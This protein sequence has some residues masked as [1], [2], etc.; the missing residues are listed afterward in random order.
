MCLREVDCFE[1]FCRVICAPAAWAFLRRFREKKDDPVLTSKFVNVTYFGNRTN[2]TRVT[3]ETNLILIINYL[4]LI[5]SFYIRFYVTSLLFCRSTSIYWPI[6][7]GRQN[8]RARFRFIR[9]ESKK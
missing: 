2:Y 7:A 3:Y 5:L 9:I 8:S 6:S 1:A 4:F